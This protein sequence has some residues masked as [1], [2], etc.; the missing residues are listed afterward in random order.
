MICSKKTYGEH[1]AKNIPT[2]KGRA[3]NFGDIIIILDK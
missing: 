3:F 1:S 2:Q